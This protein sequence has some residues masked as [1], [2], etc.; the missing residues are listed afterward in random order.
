MA[1]RGRGRRQPYR[2][3]RNSQGPRL[4]LHLPPGS[5][6]LL[7]GH[8]LLGGPGDTKRQAAGPS[9]GWGVWVHVW[10]LWLLGKVK[11]M[12][13][14]PAPLWVQSPHGHP[15]KKNDWWENAPTLG[16]P[17]TL[18]PSPSICTLTLGPELP[19]TPGK[20]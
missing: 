12:G 2:H 15:E 6:A 7:S 16:S 1:A 17:P 14:S 13:A 20:P 8:A 4:R 3:V 9:L 11:K 5:Q 10:V 19:G 18:Y